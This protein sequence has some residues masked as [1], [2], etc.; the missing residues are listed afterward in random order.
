MR[1]SFHH[2]HI[3]ISDLGHY[4]AQM[5]ELVEE[6]GQLDVAGTWK[7]EVVKLHGLDAIMTGITGATKNTHKSE[8]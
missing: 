5:V 7:E 3:Q 8:S 6:L 4:L 2:Q 1:I